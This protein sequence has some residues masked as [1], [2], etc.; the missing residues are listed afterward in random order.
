MCSFDIICMRKELYQIWERGRER[1]NSRATEPKKGTKQYIK[2]LKIIFNECILLP[3]LAFCSV[4]LWAATKYRHVLYPARIRGWWA[5]IFFFALE[6]FRTMCDA[7]LMSATA[8]SNDNKNELISLKKKKNMIIILCVH[9]FVKS[10]VPNDCRFPCAL[11]S[12]D[13]FYH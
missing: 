8:T 10:I 5:C 13:Y 11:I 6:L 1:D 2:L 9:I 7:K 12:V 3:A 4:N